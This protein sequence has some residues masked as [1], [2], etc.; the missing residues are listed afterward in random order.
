[1][2]CTTL[3][4]AKFERDVQWIPLIKRVIFYLLDTEDL[5]SHSSAK[6]TLTTPYICRN[7]YWQH[8]FCKWNI[9]CEQG[10]KLLLHRGCPLLHTL[11]N[12][13]HEG[14]SKVNISVIG[15]QSW[16]GNNVSPNSL[17]TPNKSKYRDFCLSVNFKSRFQKCDELDLFCWHH[18]TSKRCRLFFCP[19][20][21]PTGL[22]D[23]AVSPSC[24]HIGLT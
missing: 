2:R 21:T 24:N 3:N 6:T 5:V 11:R 20:S 1:M 13:Q 23:F 4:Y 9:A 7:H 18:W 22:V 19:K 8:S 17:S 14:P 16:T 12:T 15:Y 10:S